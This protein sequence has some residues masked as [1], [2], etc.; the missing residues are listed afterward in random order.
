MNIMLVSELIEKVA[1]ICKKAGVKRL[2][3]L[4]EDIKNIGRKISKNIKLY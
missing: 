2:E 3:L 1:D 4:L